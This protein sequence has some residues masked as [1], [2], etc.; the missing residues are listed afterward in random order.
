MGNTPK[1]KPVKPPI[2]AV[3]DQPE[4][5]QEITVPTQLIVS[6]FEVLNSLREI[7]PG[8]NAGHMRGVGNSVEALLRNAGVIKE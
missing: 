7:P 4:I 8:A 6:L 5:P 1:A 2:K 3:P